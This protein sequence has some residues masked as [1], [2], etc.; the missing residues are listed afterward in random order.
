MN[1]REP[2]VAP[3]TLV[4][5]GLCKPPPQ[6]VA[7]AFLNFFS[8]PC[9][10]SRFLPNGECVHGPHLL[11]RLSFE[12]RPGHF[13]PSAEDFHQLAR[14]WSPTMSLFILT[15]TSA[16]YALLKAKDKKLFK[17]G[18]PEDASSAEG[19]SN[20]YVQLSD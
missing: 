15:E 18:L 2:V 10:I 14:P 4:A 3:S 20:L 5:V 11:F 17:H 19:V 16:G 8:L 6:A 1:W 12:F 7:G 9:K 13:C